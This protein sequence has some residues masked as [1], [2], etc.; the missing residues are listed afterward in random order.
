[1][2][3]NGAG[4]VP[5]YRVGAGGGKMDVTKRNVDWIGMG[6]EIATGTGATESS[7]ILR[8]PSSSLAP[9]P[10][11]HLG[12]QVAHSHPHTFLRD[13]AG[14]FLTSLGRWRCF[15]VRASVKGDL[16]RGACSKTGQG[17][18]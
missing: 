2:E 18:V 15:S 3:Q 5:R 14:S 6:E 16:L 1:M 10:L 17:E 13:I 8:P 4:Q 7:S 11:I 9:L 12:V